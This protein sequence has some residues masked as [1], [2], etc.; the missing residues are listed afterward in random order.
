MQALTLKQH[1]F[2][3]H[4]KNNEIVVN[5]LLSLFP[6]LGESLLEDNAACVRWLYIKYFLLYR[7]EVA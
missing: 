6:L 4:M 1:P 5:I 2:C 7:E 3:F